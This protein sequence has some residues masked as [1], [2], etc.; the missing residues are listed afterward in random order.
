M[1]RDPLLMVRTSVQIPRSV[2]DALALRW[3][4]LSQ[5]ERIRMALA[6]VVEPGPRR[7]YP[8]PPR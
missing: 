5:S 3:P 8:T 2:L 1:S 7:L 4:T 6:L